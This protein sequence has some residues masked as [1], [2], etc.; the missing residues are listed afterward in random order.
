[1]NPYSDGLSKKARSALNV[2]LSKIPPMPP[3]FSYDVTVR[4]EVEH[5]SGDV[6]QVGITDANPFPLD[7][8]PGRLP[9]P[10]YARQGKL[11]II[12]ETDWSDT[13]P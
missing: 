13:S 5:R 12:I 2:W 8:S 1:M 11:R 4:H 10:V 3:P 6:V 9:M 7:G